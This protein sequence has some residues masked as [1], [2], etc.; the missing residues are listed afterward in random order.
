MGEV[1]GVGDT[2]GDSGESDCGGAIDDGVVCSGYWAGNPGVEQAR[3][4][5]AICDALCYWED[6]GVEA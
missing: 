3:G 1:R 2:G 6:Y 4:E 5:V